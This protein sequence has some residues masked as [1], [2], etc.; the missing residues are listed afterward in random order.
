MKPSF[1]HAYPIFIL[2]GLALVAAFVAKQSLVPPTYGQY[3][4]Y[5]GAA[6]AQARKKP[7]RYLGAKTC[8]KCHAKEA[9]L[10]A[11]DA[12]F[13]VQCEACHGPGAAHAK[14]K[15]GHIKR[16]SGQTFC[17]Q[18]HQQL[19][20]RPG[21]FAQIDWRKHYAF[22]GVKELKTPCTTCHDPHEPLY[23]DRDLATARLHPVV[24]RCRDCHTD[25][26]RD[27][28]TP[29]PANHPAIFQCKHCHKARVA[30]FAKRAH[31]KVRCTTC[32][33]FFKQS[34]FAGRIIR[35]ADPRFC[36]LCHRDGE[37]RSD[38]AP[39]GIE[40]P[41]HREDV[42]EGPEDKNKRCIDCHKDKIHLSGKKEQSDG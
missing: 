37:F 27:E 16:P 9:K 12:H 4:P 13:R 24:H 41:G 2:V 38:S 18:C 11:K 36:L 32:H 33:I 3:G 23:M 39:P 10:H 17:L 20:A 25:K 5:R 28:K 26:A 7:T 31:K 15:K 35:D 8:S 6:V 29:R 1:K 19:A 22:V 34:A 14:A 30:D 21:A 42:S 40:W